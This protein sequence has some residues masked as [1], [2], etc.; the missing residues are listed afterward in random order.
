MGN[1]NIGFLCE[2]WRQI[3]LICIEVY[4]YSYI[5]FKTLANKFLKWAGQKK[6]SDF[7]SLIKTDP[8]IK[9]MTIKVK[10]N[11]SMYPSNKSTNATIPPRKKEKIR[12]LI[13]WR[14]QRKFFSLCSLPST[15]IK[16]ISKLCSNASNINEICHIVKH[17]AALYRVPILKYEIFSVKFSVSNTFLSAGNIDAFWHG[18]I[19]FHWFIQ[20]SYTSTHLN[21][22]FW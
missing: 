14:V 4:V 3:N 9:A 12:K 16:F 10:L 18:I 22:D 17:K 13:Y 21:T 15:P 11:E 8:I 6:S 19:F 1:G 7:T 2:W 5:S 20:F